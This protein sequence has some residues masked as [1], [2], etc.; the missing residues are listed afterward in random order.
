[1]ITRADRWSTGNGRALDGQL[2]MLPDGVYCLDGRGTE[3]NS[4][5]MRFATACRRILKFDVQK[6]KALD[7]LTV[8]A[9]SNTIL[10]KM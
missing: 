6:M 5:S 3:R 1:M 10:L 8:S 9:D 4:S 7:P 2:G